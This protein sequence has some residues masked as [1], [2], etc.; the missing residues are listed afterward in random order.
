MNRRFQLSA[1]A[2][3][4]LIGMGLSWLLLSS[5]TRASWAF[6]DVKE[7]VSQSRSVTYQ[8]TITG[9]KNDPWPDPYIRKMMIL[10]PGRVRQ[11]DTSIGEVYVTNVKEGRTLRI[12]HKQRKAAVYPLYPSSEDFRPPWTDF[13]EILKQVP[14]GATRRIGEKE[15]DGRKVIEFL[16]E[17]DGTKHIFAVDAATKLPVR[18]EVIR[19]KSQRRGELREVCSDFVFHA[20]LDE[21]LFSTA[22]PEGYE[23]EERVP[24]QSSDVYPEKDAETLVLSPT[25]GMGPAKFG[26]ASEE[27]IRL[28][29]KP[30]C[31]TRIEAREPGG[32]GDTQCLETLEYESRGFHIGVNSKPD[33]GMTGISCFSQ[34]RSGPTVRDF[35][36]RTK[37]GIKLGASWEDVL[38]TY[39]KADVERN[40]YLY[41]IRLGWQFT[42]RNKRLCGIHVSRPL[43]ERIEFKVLD[44]GSVLR[45]VKGAKIEFDEEGR[46]KGMRPIRS[47]GEQR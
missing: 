24:D 19:P 43:D 25:S 23:V 47:G 18:M 27:I 22:P 42:F 13:P 6:T 21:S 39:G 15:I 14:A 30:D 3:V 44:D 46:P 17:E 12:W 45:Y 11:E 40:D 41:Y 7:A 9:W 10:E 5:F 34:Q 33:V 32:K 2:A 37:D 20:E 31:I 36:G 26:M 1:G 35:V 8:V 29:G 4:V 38:S 28:L 16:W